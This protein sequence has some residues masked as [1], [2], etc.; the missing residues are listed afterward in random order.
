MPM[1]PSRSSSRLGTLVVLVG[2]L[3][4]G[5]TQAQTITGSITGT[6][7]DSSGAIVPGSKVTVTNEATGA[8]RT[9]ITTENGV[10][11]FTNLV[12]TT[13]SVKIEQPGFRPVTRT[14]LT[15]T[16]GDRLALGSIQ[17]EVGQTS[18]AISVTSEVAALNTESADVTATLG[19][20]QI[21]DLVVKGRDFMNLV[22]LLPGVAQQ[23]GGDVA[24]GTFGVQ[25]PS[26]GGIR[27]VYN[28][29]TLDGARGNDPGGPAFFSTGVAVDA[30]SEIK[31]VTSAYVAETG[32]NPGASTKLTT[33]SGTRDFHGTA[34]AFK[35][36]KAF[37]A[38]DFFVNRQGLSAFPYRLT[39]AVG[40][41]GGAIFNPFTFNPPGRRLVLFLS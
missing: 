32:P 30:L 10:F 16:S 6:V 19:T 33:K 3:L 2:F 23:G 9:L 28:N 12:P 14:A 5:V 20:S 38:N 24:G 22:K 21:S 36:D 25:S 18:E 40:A 7:V 8:E 26:V 11:I 41:G 27:A 29:L 13:Y 17:L 31:I 15:L 37:N 1:C 34:Y 39:T 4:V 35:R